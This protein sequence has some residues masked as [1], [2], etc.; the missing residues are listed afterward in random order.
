M[1]DLQVGAALAARALASSGSTTT[2]A[3]QGEILQ[4]VK[5]ANTVVDPSQFYSVQWQPT[6]TPPV[7]TVFVQYKSTGNVQP[8]AFPDPDPL[9]LGSQFAMQARSTYRLMH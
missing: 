5:V 9:R 6:Q 3:Q 4:N 7:V 2:S 8:P 1:R